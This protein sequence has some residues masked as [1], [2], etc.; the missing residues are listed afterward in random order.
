M[1]RGVHARLP[2]EAQTQRWP[3]TLATTDVSR[4]P[5]VEPSGV[6]L[7]GVGALAAGNCFSPPALVDGNDFRLGSSITRPSMTGIPCRVVCAILDWRSLPKY[8][9]GLSLR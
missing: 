7:I 8:A 5:G 9:Q 2:R 6:T 4:I 1:D 3:L